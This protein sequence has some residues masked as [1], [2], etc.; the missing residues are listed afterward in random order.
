MKTYCKGVKITSDEHLAY[1]YGEFWKR[2]HT[3]PEFAE[4][5]STPQD[6]LFEQIRRIVEGRKLDLPQISYFW[7]TEPTNGKRRLIGREHPMQQFLNHLCVLAMQDLFSAKAMYHQCAS[8]PGKGQKHARRYLER[9]VRDPRQ[10]YYVKPDV[11]KYYPSVDRSALFSMLER[12]IANPDLVW[13]VEALISTHKS[14]INIGSYLSQFLA[15]YYMAPAVRYACELS[16]VRKG[17]GGRQDRR[18]KLVGHVI[19]Y[20]DDWFIC[21]PDKANLRSAVRK[22]EKY[23]KEELGLTVKPWKI[24]RIDA[25]PVDM[26]GFVFRRDRTTVRAGIFLRARRAVMR[27]NRSR[28]ITPHV[29]ARV[30]SYWGYF[31]VTATRKFRD[32][33]GLGALV[34]E[35]CRVISACARKAVQHEEGLQLGGAAA[36]RVLPAV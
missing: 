12:D 29:A 27:A 15:N 16:R 32:A 19:T 7:R 10:K 4:F 13:L 1:S 23:L 36:D 14:G 20:M 33:H 24:C 25:E 34:A 8:V 31:K 2:H 30:I 26:V 11:R 6:E 28:C 17:R 22:I 18:E 5:F 9:W 35:C 21:G 3:R